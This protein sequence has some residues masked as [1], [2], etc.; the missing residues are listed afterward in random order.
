MKQPEGMVTV[1]IDPKT[2][3]LADANHANAIFETFRADYVP[4]QTSFSSG[5]VS[6][7]PYRQP[8]EL[9]EQLF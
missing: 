9:P 4:T 1:R 8:E 3:L 7:S 6:G 5:Q 2:G